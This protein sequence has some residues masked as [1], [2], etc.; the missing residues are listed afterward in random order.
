MILSL[1]QF[2]ARYLMM[3]TLNCSTAWGPRILPMPRVSLTTDLLLAPL[4]Y[5]RSSQ[6]SVAPA[7]RAAR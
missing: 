7:G 3:N 1:A 6:V 5:N 2:L 4:L